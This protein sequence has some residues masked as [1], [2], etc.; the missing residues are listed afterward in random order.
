[1]RFQIG[2][3]ILVFVQQLNHFSGSGQVSGSSFQVIY[4]A[5]NVKDSLDGSQ[6]FNGSRSHRSKHPF[7]ITCCLRQKSPIQVSCYPIFPIYKFIGKIITIES[8]T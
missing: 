5:A 1:M 2:S 7:L 3:Y 6:T 4:I 8:F